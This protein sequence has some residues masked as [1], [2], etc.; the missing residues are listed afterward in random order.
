M[1]KPG[2]KPNVVPTV[3]WKVYIPQDLAASVELVLLDPAR[4]RVKYGSRGE[5]ITYLLREWLKEAQAQVG[6][7]NAQVSSTTSAENAE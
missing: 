3:P 4:E 2:R 6:S 5:L 1:R 7:G